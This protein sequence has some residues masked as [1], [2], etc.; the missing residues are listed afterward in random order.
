MLKKTYIAI[1]SN[2]DGIIIGSVVV[3]D[4]FWVSPHKLYNKAAREL[5]KKA[6]I[7]EFKKIK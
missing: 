3:S 2:F 4:W 7:V 5:N 6:Y 1:V